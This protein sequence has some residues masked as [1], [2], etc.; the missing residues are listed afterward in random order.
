[1]R[2]PISIA[3]FAVLAVIGACAGSDEPGS[4]PADGRLSGDLLVFAAASLTDAFGDLEDEFETMY[5]GVE[6]R[7]STGGS[8]SLREQIVQ[9]APADIFASADEATMGQLSDLGEIAGPIEVFATNRMVLAVPADNPAGVV[10]LADME[11][12]DLLVGLCAEGVPCGVFAR[13][14]LADAGLVA[15]VDTNEPDVRALLTKLDAG[16]LDVGIVYES[17]LVGS[18]ADVAAID[19][20]ES[21][22]VTAR[23]PIARLASSSN[24]A[25]AD[26]FLDLVVSDVG[27][28]ILVEHGFTAP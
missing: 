15:A 25:V 4:G 13:Q 19:I 16:E 2:Y 8:S 28:Q 17:D 20:D 10:G 18:D 26:A 1:M 14:V 23:Y 21:L 24:H 9:G 22:N 5:E 7:I 12:E 27:L 6:V 11:R 3:A